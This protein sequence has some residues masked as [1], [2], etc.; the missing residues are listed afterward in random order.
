M[1]EVLVFRI[2][3]QHSKYHLILIIKY[4][5]IPGIILSNTG[6]NFVNKPVLS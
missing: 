6:L 1:L 2:L 5:L 4:I 3:I